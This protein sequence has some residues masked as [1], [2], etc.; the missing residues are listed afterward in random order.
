MGCGG[1]VYTHTFKLV[2]R[3]SVGVREVESARMAL[4]HAH[5]WFGKGKD[6]RA[7]DE[8]LLTPGWPR[9]HQRYGAAGVPQLL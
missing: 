9:G 3:P 8:E 4:P 2:T 1:H 6:E 7:R 5:M